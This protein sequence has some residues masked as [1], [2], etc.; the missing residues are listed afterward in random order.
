MEIKDRI[1]E[2]ASNLFFKNGIKSITMLDIAN[3]LGISKRTL[4]EN[5]KDKEELLEYCLK[6]SIER[7]D[8]ETN[9]L[10]TQSENVIDALMRVYARSLN[11]NYNINKS[12]VYDLR[13]YHP[14]LYKI[15]EIKQR[16]N[17]EIFIPL[18]EKGVRQGLIRN[19]INFEVLIWLLKA[20]FKTLMEG[21]SI[22]IE[23][24]Q[25]ADFVRAIIFTFLRGI[26]TVSGNQKID[27]LEDKINNNYNI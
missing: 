20:Q 25:I 8:K 3:Y 9:D 15:I 22:P 13:K 18:F 19:D 12:V 6:V 5:F 17:S 23:Q 14:R 16:E 24:F 27:E 4:Y 1:I 2:E 26:A 7:A 10:I 21:N 11:E